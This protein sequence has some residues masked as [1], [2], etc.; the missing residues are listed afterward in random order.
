[1]N[2]SRINAGVASTAAI[3]AAAILNLPS[4]TAQAGRE[5]QAGP[6]A[7]AAGNDDMSGVLAASRRQ[8]ASLQE[9]LLD[10][11][12]PLF[13][14]LTKSQPP[15]GGI[16]SQ[17]LKVDAAQAA[18]KLAQLKRE[19]AE[20]AL[21]EYEEGTF[22]SER[23]AQEA[24]LKEAQA[25]QKRVQHLPEQVK[26]RIARIKPSPQGSTTELVVQL[27]LDSAVPIAQ[28]A[29]KKAHFATEMAES[30]LKVLVEFE[31]PRRLKELRSDVEK[32]ESDELAKQATWKLSQAMLTRMQRDAN[33]RPALT[34]RQEQMLTHLNHAIAIEEKWNSQLEQTAKAGEPGEAQRKEMVE[35]ARQLRE[36]VDVARAEEETAL[37]T[38][39][40]ARI[41][42]AAA[43]DGGGSAPISRRD[44]ERAPSVSTQEGTPNAVASGFLA[45]RRLALRSLRGEIMRLGKQ[46]PDGAAGRSRLRDQLINQ[47][48]AEKAASASYENAKLTREVAEIAVKEYEEGIYVQDLQTAEGGVSKAKFAVQWA[49]NSV[50]MAKEMLAEIRKLSR[51]TP[52]DLYYEYVFE[53][54]VVDAQEQEPKARLELE[55]AQA[56]LDVLQ[57]YTRRTTVKKLQS[58]VEEAR[59][60]EAAKQATWEAEK[61]K[62][63]ALQGALDQR[64]QPNAEGRALATLDR[65]VQISDNLQTKLDEIKSDAEANEATRAE[66]A[67]L[68]KDLETAV[69]KARFELITAG[70]ARLKSQ[71]QR[72]VGQ[73]ASAKPK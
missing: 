26:E 15:P 72:L 70:W 51:G 34:K 28:L 55:A 2:A 16:E 39:F 4:T 36:I 50:T 3:L 56:K 17:R 44:G 48:I 42:R 7:Q 38:E 22:K 5:P 54:K 53:G 62:S 71:V 66:I 25:E 40:Q 58:E 30:K 73:D 20:L 27:G 14:G 37:W 41:K 68:T 64:E 67:T 19:A 63:R 23:A 1:M 11:A 43:H 45:Q 6:E 9:H 13:E 8:L 12:A 61:A 47:S 32:T 29:Q 69:A 33:A 49:T 18:R 10:L 60:D 52:V 24:A 59:L 35:Y 21:K 65:T 31:G 46:I 57:K